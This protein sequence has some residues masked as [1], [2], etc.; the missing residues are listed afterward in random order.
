M[1][2]RKEERRNKLHPIPSIV[3]SPNVARGVNYDF[4]LMQ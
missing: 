2:G 3:F 1:K 4:A